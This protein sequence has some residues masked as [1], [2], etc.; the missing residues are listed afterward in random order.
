[1]SKGS[2]PTLF[3]M[4]Q[5]IVITVFAICAAVCIKIMLEAYIVTVNA[6]DTKNALLAAESAAE[7][8]K[9][10]AGD[11]EVIAEI[12]GGY[13]QG[14]NAVIVYFDSYWRPCI[15][16]RASYILLLSQSREE[17]I[18]FSNIRVDRLT[19]GIELVRLNVAARRQH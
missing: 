13:A 17:L 10:Y 8:H 15:S 1:M 6:V 18:I 16:H 14:N 9:V 19:D 2:R 5:N 3:L 7:S 4:E 12:L 11:S